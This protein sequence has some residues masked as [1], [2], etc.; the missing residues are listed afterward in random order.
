M[1]TTMFVEIEPLD[2]GSISTPVARTDRR[3]QQAA[4]VACAGLPQP[5][6]S[7]DVF[8][9]GASAKKRRAGLGAP[10]CQLEAD[11]PRS[12]SLDR[13]TNFADRMRRTVHIDVE[14]ASLV[15]RVLALG[16]FCT[17]W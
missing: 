7:A 3:H 8:R 17:F 12:V 5:A 1:K 6:I 16:Q 13:R 15:A 9:R 2:M 14:I 4:P 10:S 11:R